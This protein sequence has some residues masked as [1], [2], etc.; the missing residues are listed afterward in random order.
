VFGV[1]AGRKV[2][3]LG[4]QIWCCLVLFLCFLELRGSELDVRWWRETEISK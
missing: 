3:D 4:G 1:D 2:P